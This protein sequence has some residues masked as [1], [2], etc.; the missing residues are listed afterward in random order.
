MS[1][2]EIERRG[3]AGVDNAHDLLVGNGGVIG[4]T[5]MR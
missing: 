2:A 5:L 1:R 4:S 3:G